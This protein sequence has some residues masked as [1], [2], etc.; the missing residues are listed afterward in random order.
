LKNYKQLLNQIR[1]FVFDVDGVLTNGSLL[2]AADGEFLRMMNIKDG[3][4]IQHAV[5]NGFRVAVISGGHSSGVP[6][7]LKRLGV[8]QV[9]MGVENKEN[10]LMELLSEWQTEA[11]QVMY[12]GDDIPD[13][14]VMKRCGVAACPYDAVPEVKA[15]SHYISPVKG[16]EG[17]V[18]DVIEQVMKLSGKWIS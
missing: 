17:C 14:E 7:R 5:K 11:G 6:V 13:I 12:M 3:Y 18:R 8:Q 16:G 10:Q 4:A 15:I 9:Y 2:V 1:C